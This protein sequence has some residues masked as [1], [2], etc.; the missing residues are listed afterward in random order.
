MFIHLHTYI[1][2]TYVA[3]VYLSVKGCVLK[4]FNKKGNKLKGEVDSQHISKIEIQPTEDMNGKNH[5]T[6]KVLSSKNEPL[7][8]Y[9]KTHEELCTWVASLLVAVSEGMD[10]H[11]YNYVFHM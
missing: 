9:A 11:A 2:H 8:L 6:F 1:L 10:M 5:L 3:T 4:I 7:W